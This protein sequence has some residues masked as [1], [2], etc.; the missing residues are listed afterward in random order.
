MPHKVM[1]QVTCTLVDGYGVKPGLAES[2][3]RTIAELRAWCSPKVSELRP[4]QRVWLV[5][6]VKKIRRA[7]PKLFV[8]VILTLVEPGESKATYSHPGE[9]RRVRMRQ[10]ERMTAEA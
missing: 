4:E 6:G 5:R 7:D 2:M 8:P 9:A 1:K 3:V 10:I